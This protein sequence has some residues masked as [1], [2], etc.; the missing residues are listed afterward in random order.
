MPGKIHKETLEFDMVGSVTV[1]VHI[2][3]PM[4]PPFV[5]RPF[6]PLRLRV[7]IVEA[8]NVPKLDVMSR[9]DAFCLLR[10]AK[11]VACKQTSVARDSQTPQWCEVMDF[12]IVEL[13]SDSLALFVWLVDGSGR[14]KRTIGDLRVDLSRL[15]PGTLVP[16][17]YR[18]RGVG[19]EV[20]LNLGLQ[21][22]Q[23]DQ[24]P[25]G[26]AEVMSAP[27]SPGVLVVRR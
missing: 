25:V 18:L 5:E 10:L 21:L 23:P 6:T 12:S 26:V 20:K 15:V 9:V 3:E 4:A 2:T 14:E 24:E 13:F 1:Q 11:D 27:L 22:L 8:T 16:G 17:W 7:V 19:S